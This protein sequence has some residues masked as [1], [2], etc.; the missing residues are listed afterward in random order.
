M[1]K[2][3]KA[4]DWQTAY[5][6]ALAARKAQCT[7]LPTPSLQCP[8]HGKHLKAEADRLAALDAPDIETTQEFDLLG[9]RMSSSK[10]DW[11]FALAAVGHFKHSKHITHIA[12][13]QECGEPLTHARHKFRLYRVP[14]G[15]KTLQDTMDTDPIVECHT[16]AFMF[17][18]PE[19]ARVAYAATIKREGIL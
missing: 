12:M 14:E 1:A 6:N 10:T 3:I 5:A 8:I 19:Q 18:H 16:P 9:C 17:H 13:M 2:K 7:C 11:I 15:A 4:L